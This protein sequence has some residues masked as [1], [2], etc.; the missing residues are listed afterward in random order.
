M[1]LVYVLPYSTDMTVNGYTIDDDD[2]LS[3]P[4]GVGLYGAPSFGILGLYLART[5]TTDIYHGTGGNNMA[6][7]L[8]MDGFETNECDNVGFVEG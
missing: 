1:D 4:H 6:T 8:V 7:Q 5:V 2:E 3:A